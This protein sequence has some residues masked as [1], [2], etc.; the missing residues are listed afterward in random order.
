MRWDAQHILVYSGYHIGWKWAGSPISTATWIACL[1]DESAQ[2]LVDNMI[3]LKQIL[4]LNRW[5]ALSH[6]LWSSISGWQKDWSQVKPFLDMEIFTT[7][8]VIC[9]E[10][11]Q[12]E[13]ETTWMADVFRDIWEHRSRQCS[14]IIINNII[15]H[16]S[17]RQKSKKQDD[18]RDDEMLPRW[19]RNRRHIIGINE[20]G[21]EGELNRCRFGLLCSSSYPQVLLYP[22][23]SDPV[24]LYLA[25]PQPT[26]TVAPLDNHDHRSMTAL[27]S[28]PIQSTVIQ[29]LTWRCPDTH[30]DTRGY[31]C[32]CCTL[33]R[34]KTPLYGSVIGRVSWAHS[35][36]RLFGCLACLFSF[37]L[38]LFLLFTILLAFSS[39]LKPLSLAIPWERREL[40]NIG[41]ANPSLITDS[42]TDT[43]IEKERALS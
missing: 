27:Q 40:R 11:K 31:I 10:K 19:T 33:S 2:I 28:D 5:D 26:I 38:S 7:V 39:L 24:R 16:S 43:D 6:D 42:D 14:C 41:R 13:T 29:K 35:R 15:M 22:W 17:C 3:C 1:P 4:D 30:V 12:R 18:E 32:C 37:L 23:R 20:R 36:F 21:K 34:E 9:V 25:Y 8:F